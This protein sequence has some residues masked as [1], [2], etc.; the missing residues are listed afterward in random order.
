MPFMDPEE[1]PIYDHCD[2]DF[3]KFDFHRTIDDFEM[4][5]LK[6][7]GKYYAFTLDKVTE[8]PF[9]AF[10]SV[11]KRFPKLYANLTEHRKMLQKSLPQFC[12]LDYKTFLSII[13]YCYG[14]S[15]NMVTRCS[16]HAGWSI[17][18]WG[19]S[20]SIYKFDDDFLD[21]VMET[22][23]AKTIQTDIFFS[24]PD[25][26]M[27]VELDDDVL[28]GFFASVDVGEYNA[29][30]EQYEPELWIIAVYD[31]KDYKYRK[32]KETMAYCISSSKIGGKM[33]FD[34]LLEN[35]TSRGTTTGSGDLSDVS[36][37]EY[38]AYLES[39]EHND[40]VDIHDEEI[41]KILNVLMY[42]CSE[43]CE[44][45]DPSDKTNVYNIKTTKKGFKIFQA[46]RAK[47]KKIGFKTG[48]KL[49]E[50]RERHVLGKNKVTPHLRRAH[51]HGYW[52]GSRKAKRRF[53]YKWL[54]PTF[55][56]DV[57]EE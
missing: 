13:N 50:A 48:Q 6:E 21:A 34:K 24:I 44:Y 5:G 3:E 9:D 26:G 52:Y 2:D 17:A 18:S 55:V 39:D 57:E 51:W 33:P 45:A 47:I 16:L 46:P 1:K 11:I 54:P 8:N 53:E 7:S 20:K 30:T 14:Y 15:D 41:T 12:F 25:W 22:E 31:D 42:I 38:E 27:Y 36:D 43:N 4:K 32:K 29:E 23:A 56:G 37:E 28:K 19:L 49:R 40:V 35:F 10:N